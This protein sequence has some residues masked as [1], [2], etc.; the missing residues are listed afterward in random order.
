[1]NEIFNQ[2]RELSILVIGDVMLDKYYFTDIER[3]SPEAPIPIARYISE[4]NIL[5]GAANVALN[6]NNLSAKTYL[7]GEVGVDSDAST[8]TKILKDNEI[9]FIPVISHKKTIS[10][11]RI[12]SKSS[13]LLRLDFEDNNNITDDNEEQV[14]NE[15]NHILDKVNII[16]VSDYQKGLL[17]DKIISYLNSLNKYIAIDTKPGTFVN[18]NGFSLI[19]PNYMEALEIAQSLGNFK[20]YNNT[21]NEVEELGIYLKEKLQSNVLITRSEEGATFCGDKCYHNKIKTSK[22]FD[23]TGAGDTSI[24][25]FS[26][27]DYLNIDK[28]IALEVM[29]TSAKITVSNLG[30]YAPTIDEINEEL[31]KEEV[32]NI[33]SRKRIKRIIEC[34]KEI[35]DR[36]VFTN[37]CF[38]LLHKGHISY[39]NEAKALGDILVV[40]LN[41]DSSVSKLKGAERP[42]VD[43]ASRAF[44]LSN[45]KSVDYV[46]IFDNDTPIELI[47]EIKPNI[48]IKGGDYK[49][50]DLPET[51]VVES[52]GGT[53]KILGLKKGY[54]TTNIVEKMKR[55][56]K[57]SSIC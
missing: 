21:D 32:E 39:L 38:D 12:L 54:S 8:I 57:P 56:H 9:D 3:L 46:V 51:K 28:N 22:V 2:F 35:G 18:Y 1:M 36:I 24:A 48:H 55:Q 30:T 31:I 10:K 43:E 20:N 11:I 25:V 44:V 16:I 27:L 37:G 19:K 40:G 41:S 13:Q 7:L 53:V 6:V 29:N 45:I 17:S 26:L 34:H 14:I 42:V 50:E 4:K 33:I 15:I 5:G 47:K 49:K 52:L 23:V